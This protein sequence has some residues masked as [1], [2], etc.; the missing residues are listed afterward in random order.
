ME[1][2]STPLVSIV[3]PAYNHGGYLR[4]AIESV[5]SQDYPA[6]DLTVVDDGSSD[7][8]PEVMT[9]FSDRITAIRQSNAGQSLTIS[10]AW[11]GARGDVVSYLSADD[12]LLPHAISTAMAALRDNPTAVMVYGDY[13][14]IDPG[15]RRIRY[16]TAPDFSFS[17]MVRRLVCA[18]GP[19]VFVQRAAAERAGGW[20]PRYRQAPDFDYWLRL[21][22][23]GP[24]V[25]V[26][27]PLASLRVHSGSASYAVTT[28]ERA[29]EPIRIMEA[30]FNRPDLPASVREWRR[31]SISSAFLLAARAHIRAGRMGSAAACLRRAIALFPRNL[32]SV[33]SAR[34]LVNAVANRPIHALL[35]R[36]RALRDRSRE[37]GAAAR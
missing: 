18:P 12:R 25:R 20:D 2:A 26:A 29:D 3:I 1:R 19:G 37:T 30:Y 36:Y 24:F 13:E 35:W 21:A 8:T 23:V 22:L 27:R 11:A 32:A 34:L 14:L 16:V 6:V 4:E 9:T 31:E 5:L 15:S 28:P 33:R 7:D 10:R 17:E